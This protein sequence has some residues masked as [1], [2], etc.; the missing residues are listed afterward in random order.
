MYQ[1]GAKIWGTPT[2]AD[3]T[4]YI[5]SF[6]KKLYAL[7]TANLTLKW[8]YT[9]EGAIIA[10]PLV[11]NGIVYIGSFDK[12]LYA[13]N[14]ADGTLKW[15]Y[16]QAGN[17]FWTQPII[18]DGMLYAGCLDGFIYVLNAET[19]AVITVFDNEELTLVSPFASQPVTI[20]NYIIFASQNGIIYKIDTVTQT[21]KQIAA[22]NGTIT[23]PLMAY[24][25]NI[26]FQTQDIAIQCINIENGA[27]TSISLLSG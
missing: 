27:V 18:V 11:N 3:N 15:K 13:I 25:G 21:I 10:K 14:A 6:D 4:V 8:T 7:D 26:Y 16:D 19:G 23:G 20:G 2:V 9:T 5:G 12:N 24:Q 17:W 22:L 1:T